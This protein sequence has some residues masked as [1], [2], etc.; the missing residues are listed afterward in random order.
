M[1]LKCSDGN[2]VL[3]SHMTLEFKWR[4]MIWLSRYSTALS[5]ATSRGLMFAK[6]FLVNTL[7]P[8]QNGRRFEDD[9]SKSDFLY[10]N[11]RIFIQILPKFVPKC[12]IN[13]RDS[14]GSENRLATCRWLAIIWTN[15]GLVYRRINASISPSQL[16]RLAC[17][18]IT[19][20]R[21]VVKQNN[22]YL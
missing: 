15:D 10:E 2:C 14:I 4:K 1:R 3:V 8:E 11:L 6:G 12:P 17:C 5:S 19:R 16:S 7:R 21:N 22:T 9:I 13:K 18:T 20:E